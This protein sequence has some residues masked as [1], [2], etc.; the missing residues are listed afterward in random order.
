MARADNIDNYLMGASTLSNPDEER[1]ASRQLRQEKGKA[2]ANPTETA[3]KAEPPR[4]LRQAL[5][6]DRMKEQ[7]KEKAKEAIVAP[8]RMGTSRFLQWAW[9]NL[10]PS[11]GLS[12]IYINMHVF[13]RQLFPSAFCKLG[14]EWMPKMAGTGEHST[15]NIAGTAFGIAEIIGLLFLDILAISVILG[16]LSFIIMIVDFMGQPIWQ[17]AW[18]VGQLIFNLRWGAADILKTLF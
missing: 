14:Q 5:A 12:L 8:V 4:S 18:K 2:P 3:E 11:I 13:L 15:T 6:F 7:I 9:L 1:Q 16:V 10:V 17:Q